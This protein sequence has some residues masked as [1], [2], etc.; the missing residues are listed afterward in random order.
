MESR[1]GRPGYTVHGNGRQRIPIKQYVNLV[2]PEKRAAPLHGC[3]PARPM[4]GGAPFQ[5]FRHAVDNDNHMVVVSV[6]GDGAHV[7]TQVLSQAASEL[8]RPASISLQRRP[9]RA[10]RLISSLARVR[11]G[12]D[13][14]QSWQCN[15]MQARPICVLCYTVP[16]RNSRW[17][18]MPDAP[19]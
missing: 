18:G 8:A 6:N 11:F 4:G 14:E 7:Q 15:A 5:S 19:H 1:A 9:L 3:I 17:H 13:T 10:V 16:C 2:S 12:L